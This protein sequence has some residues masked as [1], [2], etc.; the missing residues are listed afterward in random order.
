[1]KTVGDAIAAGKEFLAVN[2]GRC[3]VLYHVPWRLMPGL[4]VNDLLDDLPGRLRCRKCGARPEAK[5]VR[6]G[7]QS[8]AVGSVKVYNV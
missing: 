4:K 8:D 1:M 2:C 7:A 5:D 3:R 6:T